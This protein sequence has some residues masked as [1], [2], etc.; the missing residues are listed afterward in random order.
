MRAQLTGGA[1]HVGEN[2]SGFRIS[3]TPRQLERLSKENFRKDAPK[4]RF[5]ISLV[6]QRPR[7]QARTHR[8][9]ALKARFIVRESDLQL[10]R[11]YSAGSNPIKFPGAHA[12]GCK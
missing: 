11:A 4:A 12:P 1:I 2:L 9:P 10:S 7:N 8:S 3:P 5:Q 6:G